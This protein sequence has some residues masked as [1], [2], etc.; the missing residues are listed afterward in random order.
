MK[1][2]LGSKVKDK[3]SGFEGIATGRNVYLNGCIHILVSPK[4]DKDG[5]LPDGHWID[6]PQLDIVGKGIQVEAKERTGGPALNPPP[7]M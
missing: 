5:K 2:E 7:P 4:T 6:E 3:I 1:I